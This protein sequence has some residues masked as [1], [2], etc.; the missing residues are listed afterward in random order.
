MNGSRI[1]NI[2]IVILALTNAFLLVLLFSRHVQEYAAWN[3]TVTEL[4]QLYAASDITLEADR[5]PEGMLHLSAVEP[6]RDLAAEAAFA[7][8]VIGVC[9]MEDVGGGI[10]RYANDAGQCL[11]RSSGAVEAVLDRAVDDPEAYYES[12]F[13][14]HGYGALYASI[15]GGSGVAV[16]ARMMPGA[17]VFN[18]ELTLTYEENR[19]VSVTGSFVP[20]AEASERGEGIDGITALVRFLDYSNL[21]GEVC[22]A[23]TDVRGGYLLQSTASASQ[24]LIPVWRI[25]TDVSEY[26]V[27]ATNGEVT[28][29]T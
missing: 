26:Y 1:K 9:G 2:V 28:R 25:T 4:V 16:A 22:T 10:Y 6:V 11:I 18:A 8:A 12:L 29:E 7:E 5:I 15:N 17:T 13:S 20:P 21:S 23:V 19:L 27:N 14:A 24:R 3:R